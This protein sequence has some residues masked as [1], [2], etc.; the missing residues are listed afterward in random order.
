MDWTQSQP[1][2]TNLQNL[3]GYDMPLAIYDAS[4]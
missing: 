2:D 4:A 1:Y 3:Y